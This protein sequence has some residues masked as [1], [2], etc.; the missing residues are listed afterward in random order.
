MLV[1]GKPI[2]YVGD[3]HTS[4]DA[5]TGNLIQYNDAGQFSVHQVDQGKNSVPTIAN[6]LAITEAAN[7]G[8]ITH[9][10]AAAML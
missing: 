5:A 1:D 3:T 10:Q 8:K 2:A 9:A 7:K 6:Q 4:F